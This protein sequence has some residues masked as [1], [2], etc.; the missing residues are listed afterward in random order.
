[1]KETIVA[2]HILN[3]SL[4][5]TLFYYL[6]L[7]CVKYWCHLSHKEMKKQL[8]RQYGWRQACMPLLELDVTWGLLSKHLWCDKV[9]SVWLHGTLSAK[10]DCFSAGHSPNFTLHKIIALDSILCLLNPVNTFVYIFSRSML[11]LFCDPILPAF[12]ADLK[13]VVFQRK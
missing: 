9:P 12:L 3:T 5:V 11:I 1:V 10:A 6:M 4:T 8:V 7:F 13:L 2:F